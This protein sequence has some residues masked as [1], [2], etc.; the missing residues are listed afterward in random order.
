MDKEAKELLDPILNLFGAAD[1]G[2]AFT[3]LRH[4]F[5]PSVLESGQYPDTVDSFKIVSEICRRILNLN[6]NVQGDS[7]S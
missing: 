3:L 5:L 1:G 7:T 2:V 4:Q 6:G